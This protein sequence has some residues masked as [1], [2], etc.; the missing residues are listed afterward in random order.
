MRKPAGL[1]KLIRY[2]H[3]IIYSWPNDMAAY[4]F[5]TEPMETDHDF[6]KDKRAKFSDVVKLILADCDSALA[7][8]ATSTG[9]PWE[10]YENQYGIMTRAI[11][12]AIKSQAINLCCQPIMGRRY[13]YLG[14]CDSDQQGSFV[15][16]F[17]T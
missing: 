7:A 8:P 15:P 14:R 5:F 9:F 1:H 2:G 10:I 17:N 16:M 3:F 12:Y 6:S 13:I 11:P 4:L